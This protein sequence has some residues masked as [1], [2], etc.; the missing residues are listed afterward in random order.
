MII[1]LTGGIAS[2]K[3]TVSNYLRELGAFIIDSDKVAHSIIKKDKPAYQKIEERFGSSILDK[4]GEINRSRLAGIIFDDYEKK[5]ELEEI[6]HPFILDEIYEKME[7]IKDKYRI[8]ILDA[9]LLYETGLDRAVDQTWVVYVDKELQLE[10]LMKR[11]Q[12]SYNE[13]AKRINAQLSLEKKKEMAD[14]VIDNNGSIKQLKLIVYKKW[15]AVNE[16]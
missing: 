4:S 6:T 14:F 11:D 5:R 15:R 3:S 7:E 13:A 9:P 12:L 8:I 16:D 2:G 1:G 10:R